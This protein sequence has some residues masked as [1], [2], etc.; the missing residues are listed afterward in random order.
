LKRIGYML[1]GLAIIALSAVWVQT[2]IL[3]TLS[4]AGPMALAA[5]KADATQTYVADV[6]S[7]AMYRGK[8]VASL[9]RVYHSPKAERIEYLSGPLAGAVVVNHGGKSYTHKRGAD[10]V[11]VTTEAVSGPRSD[12]VHFLLRNYSASA[13]GDAA[14]AGRDARVV[15]LTPTMCAGPSKRLWIDKQTHV[16]LRIDDHDIA[17]KLVSSS[18]FSR[19]DYGAQMTDEMLRIPTGKRVE[20]DLLPASA[21][22]GSLSRRLGFRVAQP[23]YMARG[24]ALEGYRAH[25]CPC[26][27]GHESAH[28]L[29]TNGVDTISVFETNKLEHCGPA[30][31]CDLKAE[32]GGC[33]MNRSERGSLAVV[34]RKDKAVVVV[35]SIDPPEL[36][37]IAE[38]TP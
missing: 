34:T 1:A 5:A 38:S 22:A 32:P 6:R 36:M 37:R 27:C 33:M 35:G 13:R 11:T 19:V 21:N 28:I 12:R 18:K 7:R 10:V 15:D 23:K 26:G 4:D 24:Y 17:G 3:P 14:I 9:S 2:R 30:K 25:A 20:T 16:V 31:S 8:W 29:Y